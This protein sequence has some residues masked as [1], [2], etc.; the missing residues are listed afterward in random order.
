M[1]KELE[2]TERQTIIN[3]MYKSLTKEDKDYVKSEIDRWCKECSEYNN[4]SFNI[5]QL[6]ILSRRTFMYLMASNV[7]CN[8]R[9]REGSF[10]KKDYL[11]NTVLKGLYLRIQKCIK[12]FN[13]GKIITNL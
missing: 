8:R 10:I 5:E 12:L 9:I 6:K 7:M 11:Y 3:N 1:S 4:H 13:Q 2:R